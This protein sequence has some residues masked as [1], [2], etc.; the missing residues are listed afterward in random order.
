MRAPRPGQPDAAGFDREQLLPSY[1][2]AGLTVVS[3]ID[4]PGAIPAD[5]GG[6]TPDI[7]VRAGAVPESLDN[8]GARGPTWAIAGARFLLA[9]PGVA[10]FLLEEGRAIVFE[11][12]PGVVVSDIAIF[13]L[14][15]VFGILLHQRGQIVLHASAVRVNGKAVL[16]CGGSGTGKSTLAA[17]LAQRGFPLVTDDFSAV[18]LTAA[19]PMVQPD[20]RRL[21]LWAQAIEKLDL[22]ERRGDAVRS[23]LEKYFVEPTV[24]FAES[25]PLGAVYALRE[26]RPPHAA[27]IER[28]NVV[29][30]ALILRRSAYRPLLVNRMGQKAD[31]FHAATAI[32]N[33]AGIFHLTRALNFAHMPEVIAQ[34]EQHWL[35]IGLAERA[36]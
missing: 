16:F 7:V 32:A 26:A 24:A 5:I 17:A 14:G 19:A 20:G 8:A 30:A 34:F 1:R 2:V 18:T 15:T 31:Y 27:G 13:V 4:L 10:R 21:K 11:P 29:D 23:R 25:L 33:A 22:A 9:V 3:E 6:A 35:D 28:P 12:A 36:A